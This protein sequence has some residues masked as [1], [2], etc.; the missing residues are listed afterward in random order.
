MQSCSSLTDVTSQSES[1]K[2]VLHRSRQFR[3]VRLQAI[4]QR[5]GLRHI[6]TTTRRAQRRAVA[7]EYLKQRRVESRFRELDQLNFRDCGSTGLGSKGG[8]FDSISTR[9]VAKSLDLY[10]VALARCCSEIPEPNTTRLL[11]AQSG[12]VHVPAVY[13]REAWLHHSSGTGLDFRRRLHMV[14]FVGSHFAAFASVDGVDGDGDVGAGSFFMSSRAN[15]FHALCPVL[16]RKSRIG[17]LL[18]I[19]VKAELHVALRNR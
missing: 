8:F 10:A 3:P 9:C 5:V 18:I 4:A 12:Q 6:K 16:N 2:P 15:S 13:F 11:T 7:C 1:P 17:P 14:R 19:H